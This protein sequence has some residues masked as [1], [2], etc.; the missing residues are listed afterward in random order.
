VRGYLVENPLARLGKIDTTPRSRRRALRPEE[1]WAILSVAPEYR[2]LLYEVAIISGLRVRELRS[3]TLANI[4]IERGGILLEAEWTK[5]RKNGFQ[6]LPDGLLKRL[7]AFV[8]TGMVGKLY[9][10][11]CRSCAYPANALLYVPTHCAREMDIDLREAKVPKTTPEGKLDFHACRTAFVTLAAE[12]GANMRELQTMA[13]HSTP[14]LTAN[15]YAR[16]REER[17]SELADKIGETV[18]LTGKCATSVQ[19]KH[20]ASTVVEGNYLQVKQLQACT[21]NGGGGIRKGVPVS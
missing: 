17:L 1:I 3:L 19:A 10:Q 14:A 12:A 9:Q 2:R 15:V 18:F 11:F 6:Y 8:D 21:E 20:V 16:T 7:V 5:N 4:D 13:R